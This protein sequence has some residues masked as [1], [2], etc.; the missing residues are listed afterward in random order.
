[1]PNETSILVAQ[2]ANV[3]VLKPPPD[4]ADRDRLLAD[5]DRC[6]PRRQGLLVKLADLFARAA[7][8]EAGL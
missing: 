8:G 4:P 6:D 7:D 5:F 3:V 2:C 1:M